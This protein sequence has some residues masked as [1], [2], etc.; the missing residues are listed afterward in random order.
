MVR[1]RKKDGRLEEFDRTKVLKTCLRSGANVEIAEKVL[2]DVE[3]RLY[4][5][6]T[7]DEI[8]EIVI[9]S[10]LKHGYE[11]AATYDLKQSLLRL[12]PAGF[13]F[14]KFVA[15]VLEEWGY[16]TETNVTMKGRC[17]MQE[18]D[19]IARKD[20]EVY[21]I[22]CKFHNQP[23]YTGLK[24]VMYTYARFLDLSDHF[25]AAWV[26]TNTKFSEEA[27]QY[28]SCMGIKLT[29]WRY[30]EG[31]G[32]EE[33]LERKGMYPITILKVD[34]ETIESAIKAGI[35][36]CKDVLNAGVDRLKKLGVKNVEKLVEEARKVV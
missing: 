26:F 22:E 3:E 17:V 7:T 25:T 28:A 21:M 11:K 20:E 13:N 18:V 24:E 5:G 30:P 34:K 12:G 27:K 2:R 1:V 32:I 6:I 4:D 10:L 31:E 16:S 35:V 9:E 36:F 14:E 23:I 29:G 33:L 19:V 8:L 15:R